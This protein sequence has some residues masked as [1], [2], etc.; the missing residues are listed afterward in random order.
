MSPKVMLGSIIGFIVLVLVYASI[1]T[2]TQGHQAMLL[3]LG[4]IMHNRAGKPI[5]LNP[6]LHFKMPIIESAYD[7]DVRLQS[8][9]V[10]SSRI[11]TA[12]Q[13]YVIVDYY[14]K[15][16]IADPALY[17][18][19]TGGDVDRAEML[20]K[21]KIN[22]AL[23]Q[24]FGVRQIKEIISGERSNITQILLQKANET[25]KDL[26]VAVVDVRIQGINLPKEVQESVFARMRAQRE[27]VATQHRAQGKA[28]AEGMRAHADA[29]VA[30]KIAQAEATAQKIRSEGDAKASTIYAAAYEK[31]PGFYAF[32][33]SLEAY[34]KIVEKKGTVMVLRPS[35]AFFKY[36]NPGEATAETRK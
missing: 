27:Q 17:Y 4:E 36:F 32:Y 22:D 9:T 12:E 6:G 5:L 23:R 28:T 14:T 8:F 7:F 19:R 25:A 18:T 29:A 24:A 20:L 3:R 15:W 35:G 16:R 2:V 1:F 11:L 10:D 31:D 13:K 33:R 21:Q 34:K 26:G 30:V